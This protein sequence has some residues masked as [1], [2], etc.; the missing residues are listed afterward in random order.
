MVTAAPTRVQTLAVH[1]VE[2]VAARFPTIVMPAQNDVTPGLGARL[3][4]G[5][6][7]GLESKTVL[8]SKSVRHLVRDFRVACFTAALKMFLPAQ[9]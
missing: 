9:T 1:G 7:V 5:V 4:I 8:G 6:V 2:L 3:M